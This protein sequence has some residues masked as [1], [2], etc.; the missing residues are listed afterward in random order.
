MEEYWAKFLIIVGF[1]IIIVALLAYFIPILVQNAFGQTTVTPTATNPNPQYLPQKAYIQVFPPDGVAVTPVQE[2]NLGFNLSDI[3]SGLLGGG[4]GALYAKFKGD[5]NE[6]K[7]KE[8][9][10]A[11]LQNKENTTE[12][13]RVTYQHMPQQGNEITDAP[14]IKLETLKEDAKEFADKAAKT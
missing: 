1:T 6:N 11:V 3:I 14:S 7:I 10:S 13:A 2:S 9:N 8:T 12:L 5:K 4:A